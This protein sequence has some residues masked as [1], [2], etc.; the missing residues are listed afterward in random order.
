MSESTNIRWL[1]AHSQERIQL[2]RI[3]YLYVE[4]DYLDSRGRLITPFLMTQINEF[5]GKYASVTIATFDWIT[6]SMVYQPYL[7]RSEMVEVPAQIQPYADYALLLN[8]D[9]EFRMHN[10]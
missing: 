10:E 5:W 2:G 4:G 9:Y 8:P 7:V 1:I 6:R 3:F